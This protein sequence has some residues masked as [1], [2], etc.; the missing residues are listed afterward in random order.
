MS[1]SNYIISNNTILYCTILC[2][3]LLYYSMQSC[4][5][6]LLCDTLLAY[7]SYYILYYFKG[8]RVVLYHIYIAF[9]F[10]I[11]AIFFILSCKRNVLLT[12]DQAG[13]AR[14]AVPRTAVGSCG[15]ET[16]TAVAFLYF[17]LFLAFA[18]YSSLCWFWK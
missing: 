17:Q 2:H 5:M 3:S 7:I 12:D 14:L 13:V 16:G 11:F 18:S 4:D 9:Y 6:I 1:C 10:S 15:A 8:Y